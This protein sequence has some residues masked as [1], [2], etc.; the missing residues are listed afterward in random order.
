MQGTMLLLFNNL[1][2][3][4]VLLLPLTIYIFDVSKDVYK[5]KKLYPVEQKNGLLKHIG[6]MGEAAAGIGML[7]TV[8]AMILVG[9]GGDDLDMV[10]FMVS[11]VSTFVG[12]GIS[13]FTLFFC[14]FMRRP[15]R[16]PLS[17]TGE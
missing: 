12:S 1:G 17:S 10:Q 13:I 4:C 5:H 3:G 11:L 8:L 16:L 9:N 2:P 6:E 15:K 14:S 7:G